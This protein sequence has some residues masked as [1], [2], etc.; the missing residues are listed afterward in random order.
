M[1]SKG[2][3]TPP[4]MITVA[5]RTETAARIKYAFD[6]KKILHR[7]AVRPGAHAAHRLQGARRRPKRRK[8]PADVERRRRQDEDE[9]DDDEPVKKLTKKEQAELLRQTGRYRRQEGQAGR[10][11]PERDLGRHAVRGLGREDRDAHHGP[12]RV[13]QPVALRAGRRSRAQAGVVRGRQRRRTCSRRST[14]TSSA[15]LSRSCRT[16]RKT[17]RRH[18]RRRR[19][20]RSNPLSRRGNSRSAGRTSSASTTFTGRN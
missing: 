2:C 15:C 17:V 12:A 1:E 5:N 20:P 14:S 7:R 16:K 13:L 19:K 10:A 11:D 4:V 9:G 8:K 6:H 3:A 18:R